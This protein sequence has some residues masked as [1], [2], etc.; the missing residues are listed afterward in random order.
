MG[1]W[2][3]RLIERLNM[4]IREDDPGDLVIEAKTIRQAPG[5]YRCE[6]QVESSPFTHRAEHSTDSNIEPVKLSGARAELLWS[7]G[8]LSAGSILTP[9]IPHTKD[10][11]G[12]AQHA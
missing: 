1:V 12:F 10:A 9:H 5:R 4:R 3:E 7:H 2:K 8:A 6:L 11:L